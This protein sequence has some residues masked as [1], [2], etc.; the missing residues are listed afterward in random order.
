MPDGGRMSVLD[1][2]QTAGGPDAAP[3][4][5]WRP[6]AGQARR[7]DLA[8]CL[9]IGISA[10][11]AVAMIPLTPALIATRPMLLEALSGGNSSIVAA[12]AFTHMQGKFRLLAVVAVALPGMLRFDWVI[13]WA[14]RLWG[15]GM[16]EKLGNHSR[17]TAAIVATTERQGTRFAKPAVVLS[18]L[19]P[20]SGAPV[21]AAAGWVGLPLATF[22]IL[23]AIGCAAWAAVLAVCGYLLGARGVAVA[24]LVA[25]YALVSVAVLLVL[26][27]APHLWH[28]RRARRRTRMPAGLAPGSRLIKADTSFAGPPD[29]W[30]PGSPRENGLYRQ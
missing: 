13:W 27:V 11:Y 23:D 5:P 20:V 7:R 30:P 9:M 3:P 16:V 8:C 12:G 21:Y 26:T 6:W 14:G 17:R 28:A 29:N 19:M 4:G 25:R 10:I 22:V 15:R 24:D 1:P 18:A 2:P